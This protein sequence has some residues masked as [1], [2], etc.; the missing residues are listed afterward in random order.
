MGFKEVLGS[1][2]KQELNEANAIRSKDRYAGAILAFNVQVDFETVEEARVKSI[3]II[4]SNIIY[5]LLE[6]FQEWKVDEK[7]RDTHGQSHEQK[8]HHSTQEDQ[9]DHIPFHST[10]PHF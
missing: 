9:N 6:R 10:T 2:T 7:E 8:D 1:I 5:S 4:Q 3:P